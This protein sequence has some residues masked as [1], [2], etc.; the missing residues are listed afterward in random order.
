MATLTLPMK[1]EYFDQI[2]DGSKTEEYRV[3]NI[4]WGCRIVGKTFDA[5]VLT[6]GYPK[7]GGVEGQTRLTREWRGFEQKMITHPHFGEKPTPV[8]A[9]DVS[10]PAQGMAARSDET[11]QAV[12]PERP[13]PSSQSECAQPTPSKDTS[14]E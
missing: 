14:N 2:R 3:R 5:I 1:G 12:Q 6:R 9:I 7:G 8:F 13:Q 11:P 4:H 10:R